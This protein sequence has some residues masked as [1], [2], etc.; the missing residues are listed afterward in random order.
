MAW[1]AGSGGWPETRS[2]PLKGLGGNMARVSAHQI[3]GVAYPLTAGKTHWAVRLGRATARLSLPVIAYLLA[4]AAAWELTRM[5][6]V[7]LDGVAG[8]DGARAPSIWLT[9]GHLMLPVAF[10]LNNLV[11]R[12][13]GLDYAFAHI[14]TSWTL[15]IA[16]VFACL[17]RLDP[18]LPVLEF[19]DANAA[20]IFVAAMIAAHGLGALIFEWTRGAQWWTA[21]LYAG[22]WSGIAFV[23]IFYGF[24]QPGGAEVWISRAVLDG[25]IKALAAA[26]LL[27][28]YLLLRPIIRPMPGFGGY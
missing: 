4:L 14:F 7:W 27:L 19:S 17:F 2:G 10:F 23:A 21:P 16:F 22:L 12:R 24:G 25:G 20:A 28:P 26:A 13:Y 11:N 6:V 1:A 5:P 15:L 8:A 3:N 9:Y 18:R